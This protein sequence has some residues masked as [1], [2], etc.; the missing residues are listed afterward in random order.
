MLVVWRQH[1]R[2][3][4]I[5]GCVPWIAGP[6]E[7]GGVLWL[8][9]FQARSHKGEQQP[10]VLAQRGFDTMLGRYLC[11]GSVKVGLRGQASV[12]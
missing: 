10:L 6:G 1:T 7:G 4:H 11:S 3:G 8:G 5:S 2:L 12:V 9:V